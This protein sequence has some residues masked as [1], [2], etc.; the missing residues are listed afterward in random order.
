MSSDLDLTVPDAVLSDAAA[1]RQ[2]SFT[3]RRATSST[4]SGVTTPGTPTT[5]G[6]Y[7]GEFWAV[8]GAE[9]AQSI[10]EARGYYRLAVDL[11]L[12]LRETDQIIIGSVT[13]AVVWL[14]PPSGLDITRIVGLAE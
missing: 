8:R 6:P 14:P 13:Y 7:A 1:L 3:I 9:L 12:T 10:A 11:D 4:V 5:L 2:D